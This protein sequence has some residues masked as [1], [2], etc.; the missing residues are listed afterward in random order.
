MSV[1]A[2]FGFFDADKGCFKLDKL[3]LLKIDQAFLPI[4]TAHNDLL[5]TWKKIPVFVAIG[6]NQ[7][8]FLGSVKDNRE[9]L[10]VNI[11]TACRGGKRPSD[12]PPP[13]PPDRRSYE[14]YE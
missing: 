3:S 7:A 9:S 14:E 8:S 4:V 6:D 10:L 5:G 1:A 2:S 11:G 12:C 13:P